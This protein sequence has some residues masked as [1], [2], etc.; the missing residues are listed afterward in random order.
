ML[1]AI[2]EAARRRAKAAWAHL[3]SLVPKCVDQLAD[4]VDFDVP[5]S[6]LQSEYD[7]VAKSI[8][9]PHDH[10]HNDDHNHT[11]AADEV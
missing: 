5:P 2:H 3:S 1:K 8:A 4:Q 9:E 7:V 6:L 11:H 10:N